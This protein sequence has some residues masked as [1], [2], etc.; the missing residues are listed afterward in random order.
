[1]T[2]DNKIL[3]DE[4]VIRIHRFFGN[5]SEN[6][7]IFHKF[8]KIFENIPGKIEKFLKIS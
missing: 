5:I 7:G 6:I 4:Q 8:T 1:M 2:D 3:L